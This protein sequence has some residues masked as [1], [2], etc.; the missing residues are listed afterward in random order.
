MFTL[1]KLIIVILLTGYWQV[2]YA[3]SGKRPPNFDGKRLTPK[4]YDSPFPKD[5]GTWCDNGRI[6]IRASKS[7]IIWF[8]IFHP[9]DRRWYL[10]KNNLNLVTRVPGKKWQNT[11]LEK[12]IPTVKIIEE[13]K[14]KLIVRYHYSFSSGAKIYT[15]MFLAAAEAKVRFIVHQDKASAPINGFQWH[16]TFGQAEAVSLLEFDDKK[17][18]A[19]KLPRPFP[20]GRLKIQHMQWFKDI[21][22]L[23]FHFSGVETK[24]RDPANPWW[25]SRVLGLK[26]HVSWKMKL[27][28]QDR[29]AFE[30]RDQPWQPHW[31][32]PKT[33]PWI[34]G[35]WLVRRGLFPEGDEISF[36]ISRI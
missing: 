35:L 24:K 5:P 16:I 6:R 33:I 8:D 32:V 28:S 36:S 4:A 26:Q 25:M 34:E 14:D 20:G 27:R 12:L 30:A 21:K 22:K 29:F 11:E 31:K 7:G 17:I 1:K 13:T 3:T 10:A 15:D 2:G 9:Q 19:T 18:E 23:D